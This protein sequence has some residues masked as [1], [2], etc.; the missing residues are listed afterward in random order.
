MLGLQV[1][2]PG[3]GVVKL[4]AGLFQ[5]VNGFGVGDAA[6]VRVCH[7]VQ[8]VDQTLVHEGVEEIH[9]VRALFHDEADDIFNH[10]FRQVH[11]VVQVSKAISGSII[12]NSA[13]WRWVLEFSARKVGPKV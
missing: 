8:P 3:D 1:A 5:D 6:E 10:V 11:V 13:A 7:M 12:Q 9:L 4:V 2:A